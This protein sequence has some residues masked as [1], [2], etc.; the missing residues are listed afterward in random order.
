MRFLCFLF[1]LYP[2]CLLAQDGSTYQIRTIAFY[3]LE[4]LFDTKNDTLIFDDDRTPTGKDNWTE[5]RYQQKTRAN[6]KGY[7]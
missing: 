6:V 2:L 7:I 4:N 5:E 3:N 1:F